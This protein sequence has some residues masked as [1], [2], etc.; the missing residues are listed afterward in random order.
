MEDYPRNTFAL[1]SP[2]DFL[3]KLVWEV[4]RLEAIPPTDNPAYVFQLITCAN[5]AWHMTDWV[6]KRFFGDAPSKLRELRERLV[7][8]CRG[9]QICREIADAHKHCGVDRKPDAAI[10]D[11]FMLT[12][13]DPATAET[14]WFLLDGEDIHDP[15]TLMIGVAKFWIE[16]LREHE[17]A[18][19]TPL[20]VIYDPKR[21]TL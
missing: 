14:N 13:G 2:G 21:A 5:D 17:L 7:K 11:G 19:R 12:G 10:R 1:F 8:D 4:R 6:G 15:T 20:E 3:A 9:L 18:D 16:Y